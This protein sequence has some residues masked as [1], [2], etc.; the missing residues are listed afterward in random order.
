MSLHNSESVTEGETNEEAT[1][2]S[3]SAP[4]APSVS[5]T[6]SCQ[7]REVHVESSHAVANETPTIPHPVVPPIVFASRVPSAAEQSSFFTPNLGETPPLVCPN[8][9]GRLIGELLTPVIPTPPLPQSVSPTMPSFRSQTPQ[10]SMETGDATA[11][12]NLKVGM[13]DKTA[14]F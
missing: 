13:Y 9:P 7:P 6:A 8:A 14:E 5:D 3:S 2:M 4:E 11:G 12:I 10:E 1:G